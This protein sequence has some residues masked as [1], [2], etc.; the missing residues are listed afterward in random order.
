MA[1][2]GIRSQGEGPRTNPKEEAMTFSPRR[3]ILLLCAAFL[4]VAAAHSQP[5]PQ[6]AQP[7][8]TCPSLHCE[9]GGFLPCNTPPCGAIDNCSF[10]CGGK[11]ILCAHCVPV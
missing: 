7:L 5:G 6:G 11:V 1:R 8:T 4:L 3:G 10:I 9:G 2:V